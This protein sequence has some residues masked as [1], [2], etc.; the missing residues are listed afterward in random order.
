MIRQ[1]EVIRIGHFAKPHGIKGEI[2]LVVDR[3]VFD[4]ADETCFIVCDVE[5]ILVP[6]FVEDFRYKTDTTMLLKLEGV[7]SEAAAREFSNRTVYYPVAKLDEEA[8][9][10]EMGWEGLIGFRVIDKAAGTLGEIT[11]VDDSTE[12]VLLQIDHAG[13]ELLI[14]AVEA[15]IEDFDTARKELHMALPEGLLDL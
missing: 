5:G 7:D 14:P 6:F 1:E 9:L 13:Q 11:D 2:T 3:D 8:G 12:N 4:E 10:E 15:F